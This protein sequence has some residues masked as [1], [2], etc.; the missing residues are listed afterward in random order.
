MTASDDLQVPQVAR[1]REVRDFARSE[2]FE[3]TFQEG[4]DLVEETAAY[5]DGDGRRESKML[6]RQ[7]A[8]AYAGESMKLTTR[9]MQIASWLLVQRAVREGDMTPEAACEPRYRLAERR[10]ETE[11]TN[12]EIPIALVE[13]LVRAEKLHDRV[14]YLD[15]RMYLDAAEDG[16]VNPVLTQMGMLEAAFRA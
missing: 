6:S 3:R 15:R 13:Y 12:P 5:L 7:A 11:P 16:D 14:M 10:P 2:L 8:L 9:L 1:T 4:M